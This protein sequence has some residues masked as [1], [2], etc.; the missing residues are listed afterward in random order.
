MLE[1]KRDLLV[2]NSNLH[3]RQHTLYT[4]YAEISSWVLLVLTDRRKNTVAAV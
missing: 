2:L 4:V 1:K 3:H